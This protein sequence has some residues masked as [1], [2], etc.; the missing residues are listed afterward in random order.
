[1]EK[2]EQLKKEMEDAKKAFDDFKL[3]HTREMTDKEKTKNPKSKTT[4][5]LE[6]NKEDME[7][8]HKLEQLMRETHGDYIREFINT[9]TNLK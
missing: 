1:M 9:N 8:Y 6:I 2:L 4:T 7:E 3:K 5:M